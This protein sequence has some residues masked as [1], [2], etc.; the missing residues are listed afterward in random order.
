MSNPS[1]SQIRLPRLP[2]TSSRGDISKRLLLRVLG[3]LECGSLK[4]HDGLDSLHLGNS[5]D[6][7]GPHA[8]VHVHDAAVYRQILTGGTIAAG[9][10]YIQG[11]WTSPDPV[12]VR[13]ALL[14]RS[15]CSC[16]VR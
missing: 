2:G 1:V 14:R 15:R 16:G 13:R 11:A 8:E 4:I 10:T 5:D 12:A 9:E 6:P 3:R 7:V